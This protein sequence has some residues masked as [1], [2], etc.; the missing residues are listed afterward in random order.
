MLRTIS[1][2]LMTTIEQDAELK[3]L[4]KTFNSTCNSIASIAMK[5][6]CWNR[7]ALHHLSYYQIRPDKNEPLVLG[8]QMV[9]NAIRA[10]CDSYKVLKIKKTESVPV[11]VFK[12][13]SSVHFDRRTYSLKSSA[14][15]LY[16]LSGRILVQMNLGEFQQAYLRQGRPKEAELISRGG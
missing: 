10:V 5:N 6:R 9:C 16:T 4:Q 2:K 7:M 15:S 11:I 14:L 13:G 8:S 3:K 12:Q 1:I